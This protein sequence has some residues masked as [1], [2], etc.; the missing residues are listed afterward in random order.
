MHIVGG[1]F[2]EKGGK[3]SSVVAAMAKY[4][5]ADHLLNGGTLKDLNDYDLL[6]LLVRS[7]QVLIWMPNVSNDE[8]KILPSIK[9]CN[10]KLLLI[11]SK[12]VIEK[13]YKESDI[14]GRLLK[15]RSNLGIMIAK[16]ES[17]Y[18]FK[19]LDPLGNM[20]A[21]TSSI[22]S[23]CGALAKRVKILQSITRVASNQIGDWRS[24][25]IDEDFIA[26]VREFGEEFTKYVNAVNPNRFLGNAATRC[27]HGFPGV[28]D[29][30]RIFVS[31]RNVSKTGFKESDFVEV[32]AID[33]A[34]GYFG[35]H[36][37]SVDTPIQLKLFEYYPDVRYMIHGHVYVKDTPYTIS[38]LPC[39]SVEEFGEITS[40]YPKKEANFTVNLSGHGFLALAE[41]LDYLREIKGRLIARPFPEEI[42]SVWS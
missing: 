14:V 19:L 32:M 12:R 40:L 13:D 39:G 36:K 38:V 31:R 27:A 20:W 33:N 10:P 6:K 41:N 5:N 7:P 16:D 37:P 24:F 29:V 21:D 8:E 26:A 11:S 25:S 30:D 28:R 9:T 42:G 34:V 17:L 35:G 18:R 3:P 22:E 15:T 2:D 1:T 23:F 4:L